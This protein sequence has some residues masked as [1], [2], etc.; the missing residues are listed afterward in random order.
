MLK[1]NLVA[2]SMHVKPV[3]TRLH[4]VHDSLLSGKNSS[5]NHSLLGI[6]LAS[7]REAASDVRSV[8]VVLGSHVEQQHVVR[9][10]LLVVWGSLKQTVK[11]F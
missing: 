3:D 4:S 6:E 7:N 10:D 5:V 9:A 2:E 8:P 1:D 11:N